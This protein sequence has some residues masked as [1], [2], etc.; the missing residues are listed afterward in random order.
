MSTSAVLRR[1]SASIVSRH[2]FSSATFPPPRKATKPPVLWESDAAAPNDAVPLELFSWGRGSS[3]QLG[4]VGEEIRIY[5]TPA[6]SLRLPPSFRLSPAPG[7]LTHHSPEPTSSVEVGISCGLFHS[8]LLVDGR[9]WIWGKGDG[10]RLGLGHENSLFV[11]TLN[12][13]LDNVKCLALGG[14]HSM[15]LT[16]LGE[17]FTWGYGGFGALGHS[18]Y[19]RELVPRQVEGCWTGEIKHI[20]T[21]GT[22]TAAITETGELYTWG[23][24]EGDGRLGLGPGRGPDQAGGLSIPTKVKALPVPVA[25]VSCGGFFTMVLTE[26][27]Q[28]WNWGA[29]SN[30]E[31]GTGDKLGGWQPRPVCRLEGVCITQIVCGGYH[32][33]ALTGRSNEFCCHLKGTFCLIWYLMKSYDASF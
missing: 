32:S 18:V 27:G 9:F 21:S 22:H 15:A 5:P 7:S 2:I 17:V 26:D 23:R 13:Y 14:L 8:S 16:F 25:A 29:N 3:G 24:E 10:G 20:D 31:L 11:P 6:A 12:P 19:T 28:L 1:R 4:V 30:Y 33:L